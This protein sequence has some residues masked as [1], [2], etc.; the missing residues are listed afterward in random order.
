MKDGW[1]CRRLLGQGAKGG[2]ESTLAQRLRVRRLA[3]GKPAAEAECRG[4]PCIV[5]QNLTESAWMQWA[6]NKGAEVKSQRDWAQEDGG[7]QHAAVDMTW[8]HA[9]TVADVEKTFVAIFKCAAGVVCLTCPVET[10]SDLLLER[11]CDGGYRGTVEVINAWEYGDTVGWR[12]KMW[13]GTRTKVSETSM[14]P[15]L[16]PPRG[17][18]GRPARGDLGNGE[19]WIP[20]EGSY[21]ANVAD[22]LGVGC[23]SRVGNIRIKPDM[24]EGHAVYVEGETGAWSISRLSKTGA[25]VYR[26]GRKMDVPLR[27]CRPAP[28]RLPVYQ[29]RLPTLRPG[30]PELVGFAGALVLREDGV[31]V[32]ADEGVTRRLLG[33]PHPPEEKSRSVGLRQKDLAKVVPEATGRAVVTRLWAAW[34]R[35]KG[36]STEPRPC[37][38]QGLRREKKTG[39][40]RGGGYLPLCPTWEQVSIPKQWVNQDDL[41]RYREVQQDLAVGHLAQSS[42]GAYETSWKFWAQYCRIMGWSAYPDYG[43]HHVFEDRVVAFLASERVGQKLAPGTVAGRVYAIRTVLISLGYG[44]ILVWGPRVR[45]AAKALKRARGHQR[46]RL[47][48]TPKMMEWLGRHM[49]LGQDGSPADPRDIRVWIAICLGYFFL[50]RISEVEELQYEDVQPRKGDEWYHQWTGADAASVLIRGSKTDQFN[51]GCIRTMHRAGGVFC[52]VGVMKLWSTLCSADPGCEKLRVRR[53]DIQLWLRLAAAE[54]GIPV[55]R[56]GTHSLRVGGA[57][58]LFNAGYDLGMIQRFGRWSS[59]AFHGYLWDTFGATKGASAAMTSAYGKLHAGIL[60]QCAEV[61]LRR[62]AT[63]GRRVSFGDMRG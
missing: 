57:T 33:L 29:G 20:V 16:P 50:L 21:Q 43:Q 38:I 32:K 51:L 25:E 7:G 27:R 56:V 24:M 1:L 26:G 14:I 55:D 22:H 28:Q 54:E 23:E 48:V 18:G 6:T 53:E 31:V 30:N 59:A 63:A 3:K 12:Y 8:H 10:P 15:A 19:G 4:T 47:P 41:R 34:S 39:G 36:G 44:D 40:Q 9:D 49:K 60:T 13:T 11:G 17:D 35:T 46:R 2:P 52:P 5:Y 42:L 61:D 62:T 37:E 45:T 58:A